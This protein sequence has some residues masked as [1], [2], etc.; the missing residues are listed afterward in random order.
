MKPTCVRSGMTWTMSPLN[1]DPFP[2]AQC[3]TVPPAKW[4]PRLISVR[5][6]TISWVVPF[7]TRIAGSGRPTHC[8][9]ASCRWMGTSKA[10]AHSIIVV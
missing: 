6:G 10:R 8:R 9:S 4:T 5:P 2:E 3:R 7:Q 1:S